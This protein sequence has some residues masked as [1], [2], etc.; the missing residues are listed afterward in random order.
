M[1]DKGIIWIS[2]G[3]I[4][5]WIFVTYPPIRDPIVLSV[6]HFLN[7]IAAQF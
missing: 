2:A 7:Y 6:R 3:G 1:K 5:L 4:A